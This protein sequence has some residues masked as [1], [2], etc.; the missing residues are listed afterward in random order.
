MKVFVYVCSNFTTIKYNEIWTFIF[1]FT[2]I[3]PPSPDIANV[4]TKYFILSMVY[5]DEGGV[6]VLLLFYVH[7]KHLRSCGDGQLT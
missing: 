1:Q 6:C 5:I 3:L 7:G 2:C 4:S